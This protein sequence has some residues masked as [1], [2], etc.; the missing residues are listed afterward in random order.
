LDGRANCR[1]DGLSPRSPALAGPPSRRGVSTLRRASAADLLQTGSP[2]MVDSTFYCERVANPW[3]RLRR[4][5]TG[6]VSVY[7]PFSAADPGPPT[8][9]LWVVAQRDRTTPP[10]QSRRPVRR[11]PVQALRRSPCEERAL[12]GS[13]GRFRFQRRP[14]ASVRDRSVRPPL[15]VFDNR[16]AEK[17]RRLLCGRIRP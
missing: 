8:L 9:G 14:S 6:Q 17:G 7:A 12:V 13:R 16:H 3:R 10:G 1:A 11:P 15:F 2:L 4:A 5:L